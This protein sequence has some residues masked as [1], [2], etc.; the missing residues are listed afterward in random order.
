MIFDFFRVQVF[1]A[2]SLLFLSIQEIEAKQNLE[3][4]NPSPYVSN[5]VWQKAKKYLMPEDHPIK[6]ELDQ[7][8]SKSRALCDMHSMEGAG[9]V[10]ALP[11]HHN[12]M[13][14]TR[15]PRLPGYLIKAYL[16]EQDYFK[17]KPEYYY[18]FKRLKGAQLIENAI[19]THQYGHLFKV[20]KK[21]IYLLPD[22]PSPPPHYLRKMFILVVED[23]ELFDDK[24]NEQIWG[25]E[26]VTKELLKA[27]YTIADELGL[28]DTTKPD[29]CPFSLDGKVAFIDTELYHKKPVKYYRMNPYLSPS[30]QTYWKKLTKQDEH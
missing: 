14:V 8:F 17:K 12:Q 15:H 19:I 13:I 7:I 26:W 10:P 6:S 20:P 29:N 3:E 23:M 16:D 28:Y 25:S 18:W 11:R 1:L 27:L 21:W 4:K 5:S 22:E 24:T 9:F 30:M 2:I